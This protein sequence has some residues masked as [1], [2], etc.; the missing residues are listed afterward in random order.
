MAPDDVGASRAALM[1]AIDEADLI[2][3]ENRFR[4]VDGSLHGFRGIRRRR[5][6]LFMPMVE[7]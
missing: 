1:R 6:A 7:M 2:G 3:F 4:A 5:T